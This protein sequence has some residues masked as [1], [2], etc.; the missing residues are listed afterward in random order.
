[1]SRKYRNRWSKKRKTLA[2]APSD[3]PSD[4]TESTTPFVQYPCYDYL[5][6]TIQNTIKEIQKDYANMQYINYLATRHIY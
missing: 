1:M 4:A 2:D 5:V 6:Y 3:A